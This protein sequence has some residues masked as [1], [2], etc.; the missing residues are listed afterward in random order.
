MILSFPPPSPHLVL[1]EGEVSP[2]DIIPL[3]PPPAYH[4][5]AGLG[6]FSPTEARQGSPVRGKGFTD[7]T[8]GQS[9]ALV[10]GGGKYLFLY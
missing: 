9:P 1:Y 3:P 5:I 8:Q 7:R 4:I 2:L 10:V 6:T